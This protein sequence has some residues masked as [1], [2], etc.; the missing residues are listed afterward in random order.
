[1]LTLVPMIAACGLGAPASSM[2]GSE[3]CSALGDLHQARNTF[4]AAF[5]TAQRSDVR[6]AMSLARD[7]GNTASD[8]IGRVHT[9]ADTPEAERAL[10]TAIVA[11]A[12][13]IDQGALAIDGELGGEPGIH[14]IDEVG[15][16]TVPLLDKSLAQADELATLDPNGAAAPC[17]A[18]AF[19]FTPASTLFPEPA[20]TPDL[21][22]VRLPEAVDGQPLSVSVEWVEPGTPL[23]RAVVAAGGSLETAVVAHADAEAIALS[24]SVLRAPGADVS[25]IVAS[26]P[27][28]AWPEASRSSRNEVSG[29]VV[30]R[31]ETPPE[32]LDGQ[33]TFYLVSY[34]DVL[35]IFEGVTGGQVSAVLEALP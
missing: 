3:L 5:V 26:L 19:S 16:Q 6:E 9:T 28:E 24:F 32:S 35:L 30:Y 12:L 23:A 10:A 11:T 22:A 33:E 31:F 18:M 29:F 27:T 2:A 8:V 15:R 13:L 34:A 17:S 7:A 21:G 4:V 14:E 25:E 20:A 1:L